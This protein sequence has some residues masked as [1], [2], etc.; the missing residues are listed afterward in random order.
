MV[1]VINNIQK[2]AS[3][4][5]VAVI[6]GVSKKSYVKSFKAQDIMNIDRVSVD[7]GNPISQSI[8]GRYE[9]MQQMLQYGV[10]KSPDQI[11]NFLRTGETDSSTEDKF[12]DSI[13]IREENEMLKRGEIPTAVITDNHP[14]HIAE[15]KTVFSDPIMREDPV[16]LKNTMAHLQEHGILWHDLFRLY[17]DI[18]AALQI[19]PPP[20]GSQPPPPEDDGGGGPNGPAPEGPEDAQI[21]GTKLPSLP[22]G[23]PPEVQQAYD[24]QLASVQSNMPSLPT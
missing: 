3:E 15:H 4:D 18:A 19:P 13:T 14:L 5:M 24:Q 16:V 6:G 1:T 9:L 10:L 11:I 22:P 17:P 8:A 23:T 20:M 12:K 21:N 2:F 7:L